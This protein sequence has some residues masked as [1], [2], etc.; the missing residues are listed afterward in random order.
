MAQHVPADIAVQSFSN[1]LP[2]DRERSQRGTSALC[3]VL[4]LS[5]KK[6]NRQSAKNVK[7]FYLHLVPYTFYTDVFLK[8]LYDEVNELLA[9]DTTVMMLRSDDA[10]REDFSDSSSFLRLIPQTKAGKPH[11][12]G[13]ALP[14]YAEFVGNIII[15]PVNCPGK[16]DAEQFLFA[17]QN[18]LVMQRFLGCRAVLTSSSV[19]PVNRDAFN[20]FFVDGIPLG[21]EGLLPEPDLDRQVVNKLWGRMA[22][23]IRGKRSCQYY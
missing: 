2:G 5:W 4:N 21:F 7:T 18:V 10:L 15:F 20:D 6:L 12:F 22:A 11:T 17:L 9:T 14:Q 13:L 23:L 3:V 1:R 16:N 8:A 19:S